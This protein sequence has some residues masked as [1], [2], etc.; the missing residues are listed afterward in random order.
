[1][2]YAAVSLLI[3]AFGAE[4]ETS[5]RVER[6]PDAR[7]AA[8]AIRLLGGRAVFR[9]NGKCAV[10]AF[11]GSLLGADIGLDTADP[12]LFL[13]FCGVT[14]AV[15]GVLSAPDPVGA[16]DTALLAALER[17]AGDDLVIA[18]LGGRRYVSGARRREA[19]AISPETPASYAIGLLLGAAV[20]PGA[21]VFRCG[22]CDAS[23]FAAA[24]GLRR[25]GICIEELTDGLIVYGSAPEPD[26]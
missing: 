18:R 13:L 20:S 12:D 26:A 21:T 6:T 17:Y 23:F 2:D 1:M 8:K 25:T 11:S 24:E 10:S 19:Y 4:K 15:Q 9:S 5:L 7:E 14:A 16:D 3:A 22:V